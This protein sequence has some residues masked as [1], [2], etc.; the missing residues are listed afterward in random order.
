MIDRIS[1]WS[2]AIREKNNTNKTSKEQPQIPFL[3]GAQKVFFIFY[4]LILKGK[5][6]LEGISFE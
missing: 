2:L 5:I 3:W 1:T 4:I 6:W